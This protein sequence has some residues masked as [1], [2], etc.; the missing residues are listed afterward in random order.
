M[1]ATLILLAIVV[2]VV[3]FAYFYMKDPHCNS[4]TTSKTCP[5]TSCHWDK[6]N[7][8]CVDKKPC[9]SYTQISSCINN[10]CH[11]DPKSSQCMDMDQRPKSHIKHHTKHPNTPGY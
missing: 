9:S 2:C 11:F 3:V 1:L 7:K 6:K 10:K 5:D 8:N 4:Y